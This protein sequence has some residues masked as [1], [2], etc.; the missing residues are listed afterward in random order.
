MKS[1]SLIF[2][3]LLNLV[4][5]FPQTSLETNPQFNSSIITFEVLDT[6]WIRIDPIYN[7]TDSLLMINGLNEDS[8]NTK[9][10]SVVNQL[11][12]EYGVGEVSLNQQ[13][14]ND[15]ISTYEYGLPFA[16]FTWTTLGFFYEYNYISIFQDRESAF[17]RYNLD[18]MCV[19]KDLFNELMNPN[20]TQVGFYFKQ[21]HEEQSLDFAIYIK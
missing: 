12:K 15:F 6:M 1:V 13:I 5:V 21:N 16:G 19:D 3:F 4:N 14:N 8:I 7:M 20:A 11:R 18:V 9:F 2:V 10:V 17:I